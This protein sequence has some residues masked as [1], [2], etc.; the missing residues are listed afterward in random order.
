[1][2]VFYSLFSVFSPLND[3]NIKMFSK[4]FVL[5]KFIF[6]I[7]VKFKQDR[8]VVIFLS[9]YLTFCFPLILFIELDGLKSKTECLIKRAKD[10]GSCLLKIYV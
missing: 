7:D 5:D 10:N 3:M 2:V 8:S 6:N 1:M 4:C 9:F